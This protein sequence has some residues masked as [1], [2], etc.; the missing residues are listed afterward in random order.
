MTC[1]NPKD[2]AYFTLKDSC[3]ACAG[4]GSQHFKAL[5]ELSSCFP[6]GAKTDG[7]GMEHWDT[8]KAFGQLSLWLAKTY[9][10][11]IFFISRFLKRGNTEP[12]PHGQTGR[13]PFCFSRS[14]TEC[15]EAGAAQRWWRHRSGAQ[16]SSSK[17][18][19]TVSSKT[20][21]ESK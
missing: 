6:T 12:P 7:A 18:Q 17:S 5:K 1:F 14:T 20:F 19:A 16:G 9:F 13:D 8:S 15:L 21:K 11:T 3:F 4:R 10:Q 2:R